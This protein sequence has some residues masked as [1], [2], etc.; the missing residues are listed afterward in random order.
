MESI[1]LFKEEE[2][3]NFFYQYREEKKVNWAPK[4]TTKFSFY[5]KKEAKS[6]LAKPVP[7]RQCAFFKRT[8][9]SGPI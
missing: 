5:V 6:L 7:P 3:I 9:C 8:K 2:N 4:C 1:Y